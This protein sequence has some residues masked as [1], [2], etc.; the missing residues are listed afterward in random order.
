M[1]IRV[2]SGINLFQNVPDPFH[3][4]DRIINLDAFRIRC[5]VHNHVLLLRGNQQ[6]SILHVEYHCQQISRS[7]FPPAKVPIE[8]SFGKSNNSR[9]GFIAPFSRIQL[10]HPFKAIKQRTTCSSAGIVG[11]RAVQ[12]T[13]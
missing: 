1:E 8:F 11:A 7:L 10:L 9:I 13:A 12:L 2:G 6:I 4:L 3:I 5:T